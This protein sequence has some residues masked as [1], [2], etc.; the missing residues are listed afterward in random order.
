MTAT[1]FPPQVCVMLRVSIEERIDPSHCPLLLTELLGIRSLHALSERALH[2]HGRG[3]GFVCTN[4]TIIDLLKD[5][6]RDL[7]YFGQFAQRVSV[8]WKV[9][10]PKETQTVGVPGGFAAAFR[11]HGV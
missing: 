11:L 9:V 1:S 5:G 8:D 4:A 6:L 2:P 3:V 10:F 7:R